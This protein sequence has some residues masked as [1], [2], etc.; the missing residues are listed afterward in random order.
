MKRIV[1]NPASGLCYYVD[2]TPFLG[3][4][5]PV[6]RWTQECHDFSFKHIGQIV[7]FSKSTNGPSSK[8]EKLLRFSVGVGK[9]LV[10]AGVDRMPD[11]GYLGIMKAI[12]GDIVQNIDLDPANLKNLFKRGRG[13]VETVLVSVILLSSSASSFFFRCCFFFLPLPLV[14][15]CF[16]CF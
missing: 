5:Q 12:T 8:L 4:Q 1:P 6:A 15:F 2:P 11:T 3:R 9:K 10:M 16:V 14:F 13:Q 7:D